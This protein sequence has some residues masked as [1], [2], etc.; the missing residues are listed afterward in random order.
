MLRESHPLAQRPGPANEGAGSVY[1]GPNQKCASRAKCTGHLSPNGTVHPHPRPGWGG[2][3]FLAVDFCARGIRG[4][5]SIGFLSCSVC[6]HPSPPQRLVYLSSRHCFAFALSNKVAVTLPLRMPCLMWPI[7][8]TRS[9]SP[10]FYHPPCAPQVPL[11]LL[12]PSIQ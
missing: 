6:L 12:W 4:P 3:E 2:S 9:I 8:Y 1:T 5:F 7:S 10:S 11:S